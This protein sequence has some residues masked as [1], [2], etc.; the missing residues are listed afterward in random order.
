MQESTPLI[1]LLILL[2][3]L[4]PHIFSFQFSQP[5]NVLLSIFHVTLLH[6][7]SPNF[8]IELNTDFFFEKTFQIQIMHESKSID[9]KHKIS[10]ALESPLW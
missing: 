6:K 1:Q 4:F 8:H 2:L 3:L 9:E 10:H 5:V 7:S